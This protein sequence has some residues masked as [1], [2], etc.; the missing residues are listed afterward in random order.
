M[1]RT[2]RSHLVQPLLQPQLTPKPR[3]KIIVWVYAVKSQ[4]Y[5]NG[6][7]LESQAHVGNSVTIEG[8]SAT[9]NIQ[10]IKTHQPPLIKNAHVFVTS[11]LAKPNQPARTL[12]SQSTKLHADAA[13]CNPSPH[14]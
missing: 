4:V 14:D 12:F 11:D 8:C 9:E 2:Q 10:L 13:A 7:P 1:S 3:T 6:L 5:N